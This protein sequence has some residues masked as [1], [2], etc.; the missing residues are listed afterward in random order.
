M[1]K[2]KKSSRES[3]RMFSLPAIGLFSTHQQLVVTVCPKNSQIEMNRLHL[4][5]L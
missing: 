2:R 5:E 3:A 1:E 4:S